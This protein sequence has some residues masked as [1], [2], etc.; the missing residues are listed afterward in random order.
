MGRGKDTW[1]KAALERHYQR[2]L[3]N[4]KRPTS[5]ARKKAIIDAIPDTLP[6]Y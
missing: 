3:E 6:R 4:Q 5:Y 1:S 2:L